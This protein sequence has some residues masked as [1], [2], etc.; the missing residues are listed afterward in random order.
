[1]VTFWRILPSRI[2]FFHL[3]LVPP[4]TVV[5]PVLAKSP[6]CILFGFSLTICNWFTSRLFSEQLFFFHHDLFSFLAHCRDDPILPPSLHGATL[7]TLISLIFVGRLFGPFHSTET[8]HTVHYFASKGNLLLCFLS[9]FPLFFVVWISLVSPPSSVLLSHRWVPFSVL[10]YRS[11]RLSCN[12]G[13]PHT[14]RPPAILCF[15]PFVF[16]ALFR[17]F[18]ASSP[19]III[20]LPPS[21][22]SDLHTKERVAPPFPS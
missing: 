6:F 12:K 15:A 7:Y 17:W 21:C 18:D 16:K 5:L 9:L 13:A 3:V 2:S 10:K 11:W 4:I 1:M 8:S 19:S 14:D 20:C 22:D